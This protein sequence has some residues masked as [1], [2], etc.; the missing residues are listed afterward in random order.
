MDGEGIALDRLAA[1]GGPKAADIA[2]ALQRRRLVASMFGQSIPAP[3]LGRYEV[4][5]VLGE[6]GMGVVYEGRDPRLHRA[7]A[8]K[9]LHDPT[10]APRLLQEAQSLARVADDH[11]V[12]V[13]DV[14]V[15]D[16]RVFIAMELVD[17]PTL[18]GWLRGAPSRADVLRVL[19]EAGRGLAA[20]HDAGLLHRDFKPDNVLV[21]RDGRARVTDFG[22]ARPAIAIGREGASVDPDTSTSR[23][24][25]LVGD[26]TRTGTVMGTPA[27][28]S[29]EQARG[30]TVDAR[31]DVYAFAVTLDE[32]LR[33]ASPDVPI[34]GPLRAVI[35]RARA[36]AAEDRYASMAPLLEDL[37]RSRG[38]AE[39]R[40]RRDRGRGRGLAP[41]LAAVA[42][43]AA[44]VVGSPGAPP[45][46]R[47]RVSH[48]VTGESAAERLARGRAAQE[49]GA[50]TEARELLQDAYDAA[51]TSDDPSTAAAA[52]VQLVFVEGYLLSRD[53]E[54]QQWARHA[55]SQLERVGAP[56]PLQADLHRNL[57][58]LAQARERH[59]QA[60]SHFEHALVLRLRHQGPGHPDT[61]HAYENLG[62]LA[63]E[64][65][66]YAISRAHY[67][68]ARDILVAT[69]GARDPAVAVVL[70]DLGN[71]IEDAGDR[72]AA[73]ALYE[74]ARDIREDLAPDHPHRAMSEANLGTAALRDGRLDDALAH[75]RRALAIREHSLGADHPNTGVSWADLGDVLREQ[76][77]LDDAIEAYTRA[78][79]I[80]EHAHGDG[81]RYVA[82][83]TGALASAH[84]ER[85]EWALAT[86]L[87]ERADEILAR[88][89]DPDHPH[90]RFAHA[91][92]Q[93]MRA[94]T[95]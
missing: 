68:K 67:E 61:G 50:Y 54:G 32:A 12:R 48:G 95:Y 58:I 93:Q 94:R 36:A 78:R 51:R 80:L 86:S 56:G 60:Q 57:G 17:G 45:P 63:Y 3:T 75:H 43:P 26:T 20:V 25:Q 72:P 46:S 92:L 21:G 27:Y 18:R 23:S 73:I 88:T 9:L 69:L 19:A 87:A 33:T 66:E 7:L 41:L 14:G 10:D 55:Q 38:R 85:G 64:R 76:D 52:A 71:A 83:V 6:G 77:R 2:A 59:R 84:A 4:T 8:L 24:D 15:D 13:F 79:V 28:M 11:V 31:T 1:A 22:L 37:A 70:E 47:A 74:R 62:T 35:E 89:L 39:L 53:A 82:R 90:R 91:R 40:R 5:R 29:P 30:E 34:A 44:V 65:G 42:L 81:H 16:G 49:A